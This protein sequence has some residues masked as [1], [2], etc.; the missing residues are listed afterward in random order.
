MEHSSKLFVK[1]LCDNATLPNRQHA[2]DAGYDLTCINDV[3]I[4]PNGKCIVSTGIALTV[5]QGTYGQIAPRSGLSTRGIFVN[6][7]VIDRGYTG[8]VKILLFNFSED[9]ICLESGSRVAQLL[10]KRIDLPS[11]VEVDD[12]DESQRGEGGFG[13][14]GL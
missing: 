5:P 12:L 6:A 2:D 1:K 13:S 4:E 11:V 8:E 10:V 7:G 9:T 14:T 3:T